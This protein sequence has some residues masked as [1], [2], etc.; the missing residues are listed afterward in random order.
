MGTHF[1]ALEAFDM[2]KS[3]TAG[4]ASMH[5]PI[6]KEAIKLMSAVLLAFLLN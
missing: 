6:T 1:P 2:G 4:F 5:T 3:S